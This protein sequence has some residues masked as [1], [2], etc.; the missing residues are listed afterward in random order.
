[1]RELLRAVVTGK[2][3]VALLETEAKHGALTDEQVRTQLQD[4]VTRM[5]TESEGHWWGLAQEVTSWGYKLPS[6]EA[7]HTGLFAKEPI[8]WNRIG[9]FQ[10][11][12]LRLLAD[13]ILS[14]G[15]RDSVIEEERRGKSESSCGAKA[16]AVTGSE[17]RAGAGQPGHLLAGRA[18]AA[19]SRATRA[20]PRCHVPRL[21]Q[22]A[23]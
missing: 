3:I 15:R 18:D 13:S 20:A 17:R 6:A 14:R 10:D 23:Q 5:S 9:V 8:E 11:I 4:A 22:P 12:S 19:A 21:L 1:M 7:L 16:P 2:P